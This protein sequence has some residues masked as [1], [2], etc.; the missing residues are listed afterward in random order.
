MNAVSSLRVA[1][2]IISPH[3]PLELTF[4]IPH[5]QKSDPSPCSKIV[6]DINQTDEYLSRVRK[7][8]ELNNLRKFSEAG[9]DVNTYTG[10]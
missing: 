10:M 1:E 8:L 7:C 2:H 3:L 9:M 5:Q 4:A 6:W